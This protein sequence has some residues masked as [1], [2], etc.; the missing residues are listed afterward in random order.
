MHQHDFALRSNLM[1]H[2]MGGEVEAF[3]IPWG[4]YNNFEGMKQTNFWDILYSAQFLNSNSQQLH[5][6]V[7]C[8]SGLRERKCARAKSIVF[9]SLAAHFT[10]SNLVD[11]ER[12]MSFPRSLLLKKAGDQL[13]VS[14]VGLICFLSPSLAVGWGSSHSKMWRNSWL[15]LLSCNQNFHNPPVGETFPA[16]ESGPEPQWK[17]T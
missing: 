13:I 12:Q 7:S 6:R 4:L 8:C 11:T 2:H 10:P 5:I 15:C 1:T 3:R 9:K 14:K 16:P 17:D